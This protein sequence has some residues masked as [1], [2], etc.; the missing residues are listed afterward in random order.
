M[1]KGK[2]VLLIVIVTVVLAGLLFIGFTPSFSVGVQNFRSLLSGVDLG[3]DLGGGYYTVYYP[4]GVLSA[5]DYAIED[6]ETQSEYSQYKGIYLSN[7]IYDAETQT[8]DEEFVSEFDNAVAAIRARFDQMGFVNCSVALENDYTVRVSIP[9]VND[10]VSLQDMFTQLA[11]SGSLH[12]TDS[13]IDTSN[14]ERR[15]EVWDS[16]LVSGAG[17]AGAEEG[18]AVA[19]NFTSEGR[20]RFAEL[21]SSM[22]SSSEDDSS[23][24]SSATLYFYIG[25][26]S[27]MSV[28]V[29]EEMDQNTIYISGNFDTRE[30]AQ[31]I[32]SVINSVL[33]EDDVF[34]LDMT[35]SYIYEFAPTM[36][37]N[38]AVWVAAVVGV[39]FLA[40]I[41]FALA[42]Y[43]GMGLAFT[44]GI[45]TWMLALLLCVS[46]IGGIVVDFGG[47][48]A[49]VLSA[50]LMTGFSY[51]AYSNIRGEFATGKTLT[52]S[53]KSG[54][55]KSLALTIDAHI[56][57]AVASLV[58]W[59]VSTGTVAFMSLIFLIGTLLSAACT[60]LVNRFYL[61]MF[62]AQPKNKIAFCSFKR[63]EAEDDE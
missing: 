3:T 5:S 10:N 41:V 39:L 30:E 56:V 12:I 55:K 54:F 27:P 16:S 29:T 15:A 50:A 7:E 37:E 63:E 62:M 22:V 45:L 48:L 43:K 28:P 59:L 4:E 24:S 23:S 1:G 60:L 32:A 36:G 9:V 21:T 19:I 34:D 20:T 31:A 40:A 33:D 35:Y 6:E 51:Y 47:V 49:I 38:T 8:V 61:Y 18:Y 46:L 53:I 17:V 13:T 58:L 2:S 52:A 44:Y 42:K 11:Y 14:A 25:T 57:L 26:D